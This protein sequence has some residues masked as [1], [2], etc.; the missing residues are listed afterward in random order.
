[1]ALVV[2]G[3]HDAPQ[4]NANPRLYGL[5]NAANDP[6][7]LTPSGDNSVPGVAGFSASSDPYNLATG[8]GSVDATLLVGEWSLASQS[9]PPSLAL[10]AAATTI[11]VVQNASASLELTA[12]TGGSFA[13]VITFSVACLPSGVTSVWSANP[14]TP[15]ASSS[16]NHVVLTL[17]AAQGAAIGYFPLVV[18]AVG[19]GLASQQSVTL[20]VQPRLNACS[21]FGLLPARCMPTPRAPIRFLDQP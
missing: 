9:T 5:A 12:V 11:T 1:M 19:S 3:Q 16:T 14:L 4:G 17:T 8:L 21:R 18:S 6:F 15:S 10:A 13:G 2:E 20:L 7:H